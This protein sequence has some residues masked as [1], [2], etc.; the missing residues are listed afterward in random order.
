MIRQLWSGC[1]ARTCRRDAYSV[2]RF[3]QGLQCRELL[4]R[5]TST[6]HLS[7]APA[8]RRRNSWESFKRQCDTLARAARDREN[9][10]SYFGRFFT[11]VVHVVCVLLV[12][13]CA[14][15]KAASRDR[16][17]R[18]NATRPSA[19]ARGDVYVDHII[20]TRRFLLLRSAD[21]QQDANDNEQRQ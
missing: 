19:R 21:D 17:V 2:R 5:R 10:M 13:V 18:R 4:P 15:R 7:E 20:L 1:S 8:S 16:A 6:A 11:D 14:A 3:G 9:I 12:V